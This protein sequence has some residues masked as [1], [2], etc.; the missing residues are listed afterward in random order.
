MN[1]MVVGAYIFIFFLAVGLL[2]SVCKLSILIKEIQNTLAKKGD[3]ISDTRGLAI[4]SMDKADHLKDRVEK[5]EERVEKVE[6]ENE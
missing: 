4:F 2:F 6:G 3:I 5:L 1:E